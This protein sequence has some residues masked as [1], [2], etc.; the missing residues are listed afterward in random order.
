MTTIKDLSLD[1]LLALKSKILHDT[2]HWK[3]YEDGSY[4]R[5]LDY[6]GYSELLKEI[7]MKKRSTMKFVTKQNPAQKIEDD[8][9]EEQKNA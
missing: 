7:E 2:A 3:A 6:L 1:D 9:K 4:E 5:A 8:G